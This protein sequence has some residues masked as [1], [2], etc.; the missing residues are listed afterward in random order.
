MSECEKD[1][2][3]LNLFT[4]DSHHRNISVFL[5]SQN[6]FSQGKYSRTISLN[7]IYLI[8]FKNP[9][10][11]S[12]INVLARQMFPEK[13]NF[14]MEAFSDAVN[15]KSHSYLFIDLKQDTLEKNRIQTAIL[16]G[17]TRVLYTSK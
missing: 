15:N 5:I 14:F 16:P 2:S 13:Y 9:R 6:L 7:C 12:Q 11:K 10:D 8:I 1:P 3:I 4:T 17:E